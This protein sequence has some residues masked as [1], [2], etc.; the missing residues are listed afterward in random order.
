MNNKCN[1]LLVFVSVNVPSFVSIFHRS[2]NEGKETVRR[3]PSAPTT[4]TNSVPVLTNAS[5]PVQEIF[6]RTGHSSR[7]DVANDSGTLND[8]LM[9]FLLWLCLLHEFLL[10]QFKYCMYLQKVSS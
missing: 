3:T 6:R 2:S 1:I 5:V 8:G 7:G 10:I 9:M 4:V